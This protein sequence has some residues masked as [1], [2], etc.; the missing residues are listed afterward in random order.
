MLEYI[1]LGSGFAFAA[2]VQPGP[3]QA[4]LLSSV[5]QRGWRRTLPAALAPVVSDGPIALLILFIINQVP[6][7]LNNMLQIAGGFLLLYLGWQT[8][9]TWR[10]D[11]PVEAVPQEGQPST[12]LQAAAVNL[13]N[14]N[15]YLGWS[16]VL[17]PAVINAWDI[18]PLYAAGLVAA[19]Y[20]TLILG[21][22]VIIA[23]LGT[24]TWLSAR[25]RRRLVLVSALTLAALGIYRLGEG[26]F[27]LLGR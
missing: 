13:L 9:Q 7:L 22:A 4:F 5:A 3:F 20:I 10:A 17:G 25:A 19:F 21:N 1:L 15:P 8:Y 24:T 2:A 27:R 16:L 14:P 11:E 12:L 26:V 23:L 18:T 6:D